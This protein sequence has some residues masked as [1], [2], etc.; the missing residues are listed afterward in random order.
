M[1]WIGITGSWRTSC[2]EL[3]VDLRREVCHV[4]CQGDGIVAGGALGVDFEATRLSLESDPQGI[5]TRVILPTTLEIYA[6]HYRRRASEGV[7]T[8]D[9]AELLI[10]QLC[11]A[12]SLG[13]VVE[14]GFTTVD[15]HS[16]YARNTE[17]VAASDEMLAF[18]VNG[19]Q[20]TQD[21]IDK[22]RA[23]GKTV[24]TFAYTVN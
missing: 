19:S 18:Q 21:T 12:Q 3:M 22:A 20:G 11:Q 15:E 5:Q 7:I 23:A 10:A 16:Y 1:K 2:P 6:A 9:M 13:C 8:S 24:K 14:M 4:L 17:V